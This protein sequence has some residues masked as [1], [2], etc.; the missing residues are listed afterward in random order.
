MKQFQEPISKPGYEF[1][2]EESSSIENQLVKIRQ[3][4]GKCGNYE[5]EI[6]IPH[7]KHYVYT[8]GTGMFSEKFKEEFGCLDEGGVW[9]VQKQYDNKKAFHNVPKWAY[10]YYHYLALH[11]IKYLVE[12]YYFFPESSRIDCYIECNYEMEDAINI[13]YY[14]RNYTADALFDSIKLQKNT[15]IEV[16]QNTGL[17]NF[18]INKIVSY[19]DND[20]PICDKKEFFSPYNDGL[21]LSQEKFLTITIIKEL[22]I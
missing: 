9:S 1:T 16:L 7:V 12:D 14:V 13:W 15:T 2:I 10:K 8:H 20:L 19:L 17:T 4:Y 3:I 18:C 6:K 22:V 5:Q 11:E 21:I